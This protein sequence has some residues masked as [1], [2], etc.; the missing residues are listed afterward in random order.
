[1]SPRGID[2]A[3]VATTVAVAVGA[4]YL[5][6]RFRS[7][8]ESKTACCKKGT[9]AAKQKPKAEKP[10]AEPESAPATTTASAPAPTPAIV[11]PTPAPA[12]VQEKPALST[13]LSVEGDDDD[14]HHP[15][16]VPKFVERTPAN[17]NPKHQAIQR[18]PVDNVNYNNKR[19]FSVS[20]ESMKPSEGKDASARTVI[21]KSDD[22]MRRIASSCSSNLL[23]KNLDKEQ[24]QEIYDAMF[25]R[26]VK[27]GEVVIRQGDEGDNFYVVDSGAFDVLVSRDGN[28][29]KKVVEVCVHLFFFVFHC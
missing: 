27:S 3:T 18:L 20:A 6:L 22:A 1:M 16:R 9:C 4:V 8:S 12:P 25:E 13:I 15:E 2:I 5:Y 26:H 19:R 21:P 10:V 28:P 17:F 23:F 24:R 11:T 7:S 29:A 14:E